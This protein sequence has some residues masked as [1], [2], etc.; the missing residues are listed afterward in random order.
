[1]FRIILNFVQISGPS[2][3]QS[4]CPPNEEVVE[5]INFCNTC[6]DGDTCY[7]EECLPGCDCL[8]G[9]LRNDEGECIP[10]G[11]CP[12]PEEEESKISLLFSSILQRV[13]IQMYKKKS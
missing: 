3:G 11:L 6:E 1:M 12:L 9:Y 5:C 13:L 7:G 2:G 4:V 10:R 8:P